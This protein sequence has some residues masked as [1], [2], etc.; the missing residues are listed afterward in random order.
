[1][2]RS[3]MKPQKRKG[4]WKKKVAKD[5]EEDFY[6]PERKDNILGRNKTRLVLWEEHLKDPKL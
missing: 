3:Q 4:L 1:M 6:D 2:S 5:R